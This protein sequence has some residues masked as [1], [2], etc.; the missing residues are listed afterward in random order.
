MLAL[1]RYQEGFTLEVFLL[2]T[3]VQYTLTYK[4]IKNIN[5]RILQNGEIHI[6]APH[7]TPITKIES[8]MQ[9][10]STRILQVL[11]R[12]SAMASTQAKA[13][14]LEHGSSISIFGQTY[15]LAICEGVQKQI[16]ANE[17]ILTLTL[18]NKDANTAQALFLGFVSQQGQLYFQSK[19]ENVL[20][21]FQ[22]YKISKPTLQLRRMKSRWGSCHVHKGHVVLNTYLY[23]AP[24]QCIDYVLLHELCHFVHPN[25]SK[26]FYALL[27]TVST[28]WEQLRRQLGSFTPEAP[29]FSL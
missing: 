17:N 28:D 15:T 7:H 2:N 5:L 18:P 13:P 3:P 20:P 26:D 4:K 23:N 12:F 6:S 16:L 1:L 21:L 10:N 25:H 24:A 22:A 27:E 9:E 19:L 29:I 14:L 11:A 8:F